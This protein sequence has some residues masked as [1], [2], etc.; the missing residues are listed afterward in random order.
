MNAA[1]VFRLVLA[2]IVLPPAFGMMGRLRGLP[3]LT[4]FRAGFAVMCVAYVAAVAE[5]VWL[6]SVFN[7]VQHLSI[8]VAGV[9]ALIGVMAWVRATPVGGGRS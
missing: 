2:V 3:G 6:E 8:G 1:A 5:D 7:A 9:L 4:W